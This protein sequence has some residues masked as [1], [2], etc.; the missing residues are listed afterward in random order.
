MNHATTEPSPPSGSTPEAPSEATSTLARIVGEVEYRE[1]DG[2]NIRIRKG[3]IEVVLTALD[4][5]LGW[6]DGATRGSAVM[7]LADFKRL[8]A[9]QAIVFTGSRE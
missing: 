1:G 6:A 8:V 5:T 2:P 7:P 4:A 9:S 3:P